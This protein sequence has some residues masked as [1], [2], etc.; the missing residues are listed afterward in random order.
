MT[1]E[2]EQRLFAARLNAPLESCDKVSLVVTGDI[3]PVAK[4][5]P[6]DVPL[7]PLV[8]P[9]FPPSDPPP[10]LETNRSLP[11]PVVVEG[12]AFTAACLPEQAYQS[13]EYVKGAIEAATQLV[14]LDSIPII[15]TAELYRIADLMDG[16]VTLVNDDLANL[17]EVGG[18]WDDFD[19]EIVARLRVSIAIAQ[20][21]REA[22]VTAQEKANEVSR[23]VAV[24]NLRCVWESRLLWA[25]C[26]L[27]NPLGYALTFSPDTP[28]LGAVVASAGAA[29]SDLSQEDADAKAG[30][31]AARELNCLFRNTA[32]TSTCA[33]IEEGAFIG[34]PTLLWPLGVSDSALRAPVSVGLASL[35]GPYAVADTLPDIRSLKLTATIPADQVTGRTQQEANDTAKLL[36]TAE[37]DCFFPSRPRIFSC[38]DAADYGNAAARVEFVGGRSEDD[39]LNEM[40]TG[41]IAGPRVDNAGI[42]ASAIDPTVGVRTK[43]PAGMFIGPTSADAENLATLFAISTLEC[44][45][46]NV[47]LTYACDDL[48]S[49]TSEPLE[50]AEHRPATYLGERNPLNKQGKTAFSSALGQTLHMLASPRKSSPYST[51]VLERQFFSEDGQAD[52]N[53]IAAS[54]AVSQLG[55]VYC[56]PRIP[57]VCLT[58]VTHIPP[59]EADEVDLPVSPSIIAPGQSADATSGVPGVRYSYVVDKWIPPSNYLTADDEGSTFACGDFAEVVAVADVV[60]AIPIK[61]LVF[62]A[63][64]A[65]CQYGNDR[66]Y[67]RCRPSEAPPLDAPAGSFAVSPSGAATYQAYLSPNSTVGFV[68]IAENTVTESTK[69]AANA[70]ASNLALSQLGCFYESPALTL[71]CGADTSA[72]LPSAAK[73]TRVD[74]TP[75]E[76]GDGRFGTATPVKDYVHPLSRGFK[77]NGGGASPSPVTVPYGAGR[78]DA[79]PTEALQA[80]LFVGLGGL[81]CF[82]KNTT[83][84]ARCPGSAG[85]PAH[86]NGLT[87]TFATDS[88]TLASTPADRFPSD[89]S[90]FDADTI[91]LLVAQAGLVCWYTHATDGTS[92]FCPGATV[93]LQPGRVPARTIISPVSSQD[94]LATASELAVALVVCSDNPNAPSQTSSPFGVGVGPAGGCCKAN[95]KPGS[96]TALTQLWAN[97]AADATGTPPGVRDLRSEASAALSTCLPVR[98]YINLLAT[99]RTDETDPDR[100][101]SADNVFIQFDLASAAVREAHIPHGSSGKAWGVNRMIAEIVGAEN[102]CSDALI[103]QS[104][105][106]PQKLTTTYEDGVPFPMICDKDT[107]S[108]IGG[109]PA[110][111]DNFRLITRTSGGAVTLYRTAGSAGNITE[112]E[113]SI[114]PLSSNHNKY[115][116]AKFTLSGDTYTTDVVFGGS[117][118]SSA[119][120]QY[121]LLAHTGPGGELYKDSCS[122]SATVCRDWFVSPATYSLSSSGV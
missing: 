122:A 115:L 7:A 58:F 32:Q 112:G 77:T 81:Y 23:S 71:F 11:D 18:A 98:V 59:Y 119:T 6:C 83:Q 120:V 28:P 118:S 40:A 45:W 24:A 9:F 44:L 99:L 70:V 106:A 78:S 60:G 108:G 35:E 3:D 31:I 100:M 67:G 54:F 34:T 116:Y 49:D 17:V 69:E 63:L 51:N 38:I 68:I 113:A 53:E 41:D 43:L 27:D 61:D 37:L 52:A 14:Y 87:Q 105:S 103:L 102:D 56:N 13:D 26:D 121:V 84:T 95:L 42:I 109:S 79:S 73:F 66:V 97:A 107:P 86:P 39:I 46:G 4:S 62:D 96:L 104:V 5:A 64:S 47:E 8:E 29:T 33:E 10:L 85:G 101:W 74:T 12:A 114:G 22:L 75:A 94:A 92:T 91:A 1:P 72:A 88:V 19:V 89:V 57:P 93:P 16:L 25:H 110:G 30:R 36:A 90:Q 65:N 2:E 48:N 117:Q 76:F 82:F 21:I 15:P 20:A 111:C 55:C 80:A 50:V